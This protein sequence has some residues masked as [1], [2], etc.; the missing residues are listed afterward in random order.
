MEAADWWISQLSGLGCF[1]CSRWQLIDFHCTKLDD[2]SSR[3]V[4]C[5]WLNELIALGVTDPF[6]R[7]FVR[8]FKLHASSPHRNEWMDPS[9]TWYRDICKRRGPLSLIF[10]P[11]PNRGNDSQHLHPRSKRVFTVRSNRF[12]PYIHARVKRGSKRLFF[13]K[14]VRS[15]AEKPSKREKRKRKREKV[16]ILCIYTRNIVRCFSGCAWTWGKGGKGGRWWREAE[17]WKSWKRGEKCTGNTTERPSSK[18]VCFRINICSIHDGTPL[19]MHPSSH[20]RAR[21]HA[22]LLLSVRHSYVTRQPVVATFR[23]V[24]GIGTE[25]GSFSRLR[26]LDFASARSSSLGKYLVVCSPCS[27]ER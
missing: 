9:S 7:P 5:S 10:H 17:L 16:A 18:Q 8:S 2:R 14:L 15:R 23:L 19:W 12:Q 11:T 27:I 26:K 22:C 24:D 25:T 13:S 1:K 20:R 6:F 3:F 21:T 4:W